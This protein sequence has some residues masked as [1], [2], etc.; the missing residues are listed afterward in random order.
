MVLPPQKL[1][2]ETIRRIKRIAKEIAKE[3]NITGPFNMQ[4]L[5]KN[6]E[7]KVIECNLRAS[8]SFPFVSKVFKHDFIETA[9]CIMLGVP[10]TKPEKTMFDLDYI[11]VKASQFSF[12]RLSK[13]DPV[14]GV[15]MSSTGEVGCLGEDYHDAILKAMLS[16]GYRIPQKNILISSGPIKSKVDLLSTC[17]LLVENG[18][19]LH[20]T[21]GSSR[22]LDDNN[23]P[24]ILVYWPDEDKQP[25]S[26]ELLKQR[27]IDLVINIPKNLSKAELHRDY[28]IRRSSIDFNIPLLTNTRLARA[29]V[30]AFCAKKQDDI[31]ILSWD[32]FKL[33]S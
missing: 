31:S 7:V 26:L 29:F 3:L 19:T 20:A 6:N 14:L 10:F 27:K 32:E 1:Y 25:N 22:F 21:G 18:Y 30:E 4:F 12:S 13:A 28:I 15:D 8:R 2:F 9:T 16:V 17:K 24:N 23:V 11:G 5:A 33:N